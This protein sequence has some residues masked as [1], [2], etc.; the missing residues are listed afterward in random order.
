[1]PTPRPRHT[2]HALVPVRLPGEVLGLDL[3]VALRERRGRRGDLPLEVA[4]RDRRVARARLADDLLR[5]GRDGAVD[6]VVA[7]LRLLEVGRERQVELAHADRAVPLHVDLG[8]KSVPNFTGS[9]L[10]HV[11]LVSAHS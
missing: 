1:M 9:S 8:G 11:P 2:K 7:Q 6:A 10:G 3:V 5:D 4:E